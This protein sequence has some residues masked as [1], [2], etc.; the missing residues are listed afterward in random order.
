MIQIRAADIVNLPITDVNHVVKEINWKRR[1][2]EVN[3]R[4]QQRRSAYMQKYN[5]RGKKL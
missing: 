1:Y 3:R 4:E 5:K 2:D